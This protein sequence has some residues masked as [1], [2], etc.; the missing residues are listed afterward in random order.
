MDRVVR[1]RVVFARIKTKHIEMPPDGNLDP[2]AAIA[3]QRNAL[4]QS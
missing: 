2:I 4:M 1:R 3:M